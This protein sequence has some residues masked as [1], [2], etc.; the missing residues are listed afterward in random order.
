MYR[1]RSTSMPAVALGL[2]KLGCIATGRI[3]AT[4]AE[5]QVRGGVNARRHLRALNLQRPPLAL[6]LSSR[7]R[8]AWKKK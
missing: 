5:A 3:R 6:V 7:R 8:A 4:S 1:S 2:R